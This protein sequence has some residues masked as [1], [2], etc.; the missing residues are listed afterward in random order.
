MDASIFD[1]HALSTFGEGI[2]FHMGT[3]FHTSHVRKFQ[4]MSSMGFKA[5]CFHPLDKACTCNVP[6]NP[7]SRRMGGDTNARDGEKQAL[8]EAR[9]L[10]GN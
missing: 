5:V 10:M 9:A 8:A 1:W 7:R 2:R 6:R 3:K 4:G